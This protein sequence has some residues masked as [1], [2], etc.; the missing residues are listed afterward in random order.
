MA[1]ADANVQSPVGED[2]GLRDL[3]G[4]DHRIMQGQRV[5]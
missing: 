2:V 3:T 5:A 4:Q 1:A